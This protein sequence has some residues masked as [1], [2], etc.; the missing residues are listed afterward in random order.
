MSK[1]QYFSKMILGDISSEIEY[2]QN[3]IVCYVLGAHSPFTVLNGF[4]QNGRLLVEVNVRKTLPEEVL[5][6]NEKGVVI[7][8]SVTYDWRPSLCD[9]C[10][11]YGHEKDN[12]RKLHPTQQHV[13]ETKETKEEDK[14]QTNARVDEGKEKVQEIRKYGANNRRFQLGSKMIETQHVITTN[15]YYTR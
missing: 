11:K 7:T 12:C 5:F 10:H 14:I 8:Q 6:R 3:A 15:A 4:I 13:D 2:W 1:Y 9:H